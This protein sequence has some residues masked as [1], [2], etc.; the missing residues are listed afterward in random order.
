MKPQWHIF[1]RYADGRTSPDIWTPVA[2]VPAKRDEWPR[3]LDAQVRSQPGKFLAI[4]IGHWVRRKGLEL[5]T[6]T[7]R[8]FEQP[9]AEPT[10][11]ASGPDL[12]RV[13]A[14]LSDEVAG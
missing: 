3:L 5:E 2:P 14:R 10:V 7:I 4:G 6:A 9:A 12:I 13:A 1:A 8:T 11:S